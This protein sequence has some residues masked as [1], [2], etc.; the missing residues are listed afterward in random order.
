MRAFGAAF[1]VSP[2]YCN[3]P[4][5]GVPPRPVV[6][7]VRAHVEAGVAARSHHLSST[8]RSRWRAFSIRELRAVGARRSGQRGGGA[9]D[10]QGGRGVRRGQRRGVD[11]F[12]ASRA[13]NAA[14]MAKKREKAT[15]S[16]ARSAIRG[17]CRSA[18]T[19]SSATAR[20]RRWSPPAARWTGC[21]CRAS[22]RRARSARSSAGTP[23]PSGSR[24]ST[25]T[26]PADRRY[27][28][29][30]MIL[31]TSWGTAD[32]LD[33]RARRAADRPVA[34][35]ATTGPSPTAAPPTTTRPSTSCCA[36]S[37]ACP[38]RCRRSWT[39]SRCSTTAARTSAGSTPARATTRAGRAPRTPTSTLT[40]TTDMRLGFEGGQASTRT[41]LKEGD[42]RF[43]AL[44]WGGAEPAD[45]LRRR[46]QA[47]GVDRPPL[48]AL[49]GARP[50]PR[51]PVAQL[52]AAQRAHPQGAHLLA[53]G[54]RDGGGQ[55]VAAGDAGRQPQLR[56]P[57]HLDPGRHLRP[58]GDVLARLRLGGGRLLLLHRRRRRERRRPADHVR[59]RRRARARRVRARPPARATPT[60]ARCGSATRRTPRSSTTSGAPCS[61]RSTC[62]PRPPTTST[63]GSGRSCEKQVGEA[64]K[65]WRE[66]DAGIWEVRGELRHFTS[67]KI[68]C[69]VAV[70]RGARLAAMMG[71]DG[72]AAEWELAA[73]EIKEDILANGVDDRGVLTQYYG[74]TALDA[75]LLLAPLVR[76][77][78]AGR[79]A[80][81]RHRDGDP[82]RADRRRPGAALQGR[83]D[84]RRLH[85]RGGHLHDLL[86]LAGL[87]AVRDRR[88]RAR[89]ASCAPS[90]SR[91]PARWSS[92]PRRSTRTAGSTSATS[93]RPSPTSP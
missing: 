7:A 73:D 65:H 59:H 36:P 18:T 31:E 44:S 60:P 35:R 15:G 42:I 29:G 58:V 75:S 14:H 49:A 47:A 84:R 19:G 11:L 68:M 78:P 23:A 91:S 62:T 8:N 17:R 9:G 21:A 74:S 81:P 24:R 41:L 77:L 4:S 93:R 51:P 6:S 79:P 76:F 69:W 26:V 55:H 52:P 30:T 33:H 57:L 67:S 5:V 34:P 28:P 61:T 66:P 53:D 80:D 40:L 37:G 12:A 50:V 87:G 71:E 85:R 20:C 38:A 13:G 72:K 25:C 1:E 16:P 46:L 2:G 90:C 70:D 89:P 3:T 45:H 10:Q 54:R 63:T 22:T 83:G 27:L 82:Q 56:L 64:L 86:V 32:R 88:V 43:V 92:T 39:A 48:A